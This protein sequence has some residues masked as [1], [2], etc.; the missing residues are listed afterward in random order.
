MKQKI[1]MFLINYYLFFIFVFLILINSI[2]NYVVIK[3][4]LYYLVIIL[5]ILINFFIVLKYENNIKFKN[6]FFILFIISVL[7][8][9]TNLYRLISL[10]TLVAIIITGFEKSKFIMISTYALAVFVGIAFPFLILF[11]FA[12]GED[13]IYEDMHYYCGEYE[14]YSYSYGAMDRFH[15]KVNRHY[16]IIYLK[17]IIE[18]SYNEVI[19]DSDSDEQYNFIL[20]NNKCILSKNYK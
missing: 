12:P 19:S 6:L 11:M 2:V 7:F 16:E 13:P 15:Y 1:K 8:D 3:G 5:I 17:N 14:I 4:L 10:S 18:I 20:K 9:K